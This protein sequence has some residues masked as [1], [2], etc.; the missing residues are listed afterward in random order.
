[1]KLIMENWKRFVNESIDKYE[2]KIA[3]AIRQAEDDFGSIE[4]ML[5]LAQTVEIKNN[6]VIWK[7]LLINKKYLANV[8]ADKGTP[9]E[10]LNVIY[11]IIPKP[12]GDDRSAII[13]VSKL[14]KHPAMDRKLLEKIK[15]EKLQAW[16]IPA[17]IKKLEKRLK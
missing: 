10:R 15:I 13:W 2:E 7:A 11:D 1:M 3:N 14:L 4:Q 6:Q 5:E 12:M 8:L 17:R 16:P 9:S